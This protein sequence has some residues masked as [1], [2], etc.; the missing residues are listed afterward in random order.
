MNGCSASR[1]SYFNPVE[2]DPDTHWTQHWV[3][4]SIGLNIV[5][6]GN[7]TLVIEAIFSK[8]PATHRAVCLFNHAVIVSIYTG[9]NG[10]INTELERIWKNGIATFT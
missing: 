3:S 9:T 2:R 10:M 6:D 8:Q 7:R 1:S 5:P 4:P